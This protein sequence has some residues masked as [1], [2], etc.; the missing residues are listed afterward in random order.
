MR[1]LICRLTLAVT[2]LIVAA[3]AGCTTGTATT[4]DS[5]GSGSPHEVRP[6]GSGEARPHDPPAK[7][8]DP[9]DGGGNGK[10]DRG[11]QTKAA[12]PGIAVSPESVQLPCPGADCA[13]PVTIRSTGSA[14]LIIY[15]M[16]IHNDSSKVVEGYHAILPRQCIDITLQPGGSCTFYVSW[17]VGNNQSD[18]YTAQLLIFDNLPDQPTYVSL[19]RQPTGPIVGS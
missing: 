5:S 13:Q 16:S 8:P 10:K 2:V 15:D 17:F 14:A 3:A 11:P 1:S 4:P 12:A 7:S 19:T 18:I 6:P 9:G